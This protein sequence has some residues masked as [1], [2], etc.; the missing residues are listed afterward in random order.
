MTFIWVVFTLALFILEPLFLQKWFHK[1]AEINNEKALQLLG[2]M[3]VL[4]LSLSILVMISVVGRS[5][6]LIFKFFPTEQ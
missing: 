2:I 3:Y 4:L 1:Q 6:G 5:H